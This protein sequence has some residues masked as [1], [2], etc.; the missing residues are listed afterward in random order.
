MTL[1]ASGFPG[2]AESGLQRNYAAMSRI[3]VCCRCFGQ[4]EADR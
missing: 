4:A 1:G 3:P 2:G